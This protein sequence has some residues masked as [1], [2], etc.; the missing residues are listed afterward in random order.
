METN[1]NGCSVKGTE[2]SCNIV[3]SEQISILA[4][5]NNNELPGVVDLEA[6]LQ[7]KHPE[8]VINEAPIAPN[9]IQVEV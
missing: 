7:V 9:D 2:D 8:S 5:Q 3:E 6:Q 4:D 1:E